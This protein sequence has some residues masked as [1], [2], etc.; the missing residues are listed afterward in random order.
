M[1][2]PRV[3]INVSEK[4]KKWLN[5]AVALLIIYKRNKNTHL[6][7]TCAQMYTALFIITKKGKQPKCPSTDKRMNKMWYVHTQ[8]YSE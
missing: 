2:N 4:V 1:K 6:R 5:L 3:E 7:K 8:Y